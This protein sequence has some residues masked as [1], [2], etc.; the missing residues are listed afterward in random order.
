MRCLPTAPVHPLKTPSRHTRLP[1]SLTPTHPSRPRA[2]A[3]H[4]RALGELAVAARASAAPWRTALV[5]NPVSLACAP[6]P[7]R[8]TTA[9]L[10]NYPWSSST[11]GEKSSDPPLLSHLPPP[12]PLRPH[13][14]TFMTVPCR[15]DKPSEKTLL[16]DVP[17]PTYT[18]NPGHGAPRHAW[19]GRDEDPDTQAPLSASPMPIPS[20]L[21][22][23][24]PANGPHSLARL[25][26]SPHS[27]PPH[28]ADQRNRPHR[29]PPVSHHL[30]TAHPSRWPVGLKRRTPRAPK[31]RR[32]SRAMC[33]AP[34]NAPTHARTRF[35]SHEIVLMPL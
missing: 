11:M 23:G 3:T 12:L 26:A 8:S 27:H 21:H 10:S 35:G 18:T 13:Q 28:F 2:T 17:L 20:P 4:H 31:R 15:W 9:T 1:P 5:R 34:G 7:S 16:L 25:R 33:R 19:A 14:G 24:S 22:S 6:A 30:L 32:P 29:G